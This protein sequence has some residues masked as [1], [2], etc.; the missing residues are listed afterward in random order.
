MASDPRSPRLATRLPAA[1]S[2]RLAAQSSVFLESRLPESRISESDPVTQPTAELICFFDWAC[3]H[4]AQRIWPRDGPVLAA[5]PVVLRDGSRRPIGLSM[6]IRCSPAHLL[7][8]PTVPDDSGCVAL[9]VDHLAFRALLRGTG[10]A[11]TVFPV[12]WLRLLLADLPLGFSLLPSAVIQEI[13]DGIPG[14]SAAGDVTPRSTGQC[15]IGGGLEFSAFL[16]AG[17]PRQGRLV[18]HGPGGG[19]G[20]Y[21]VQLPSL[22]SVAACSTLVRAACT[23]AALR[24]ATAAGASTA[25]TA[26]SSL[27]SSAVGGLV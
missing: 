16:D 2:A 22:P 4:W 23:A 5:Q 3:K 7:S 10:Q 12:P 15:T 17:V 26:A 6:Q 8:Q 1:A 18:F 13:I 24:A 25:A 9:H 11:A 14:F 27:A 19:T 20:S 21:A